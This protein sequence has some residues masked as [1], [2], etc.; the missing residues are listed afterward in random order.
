[1][2][3]QFEDTFPQ[4][5]ERVLDR[6]KGVRKSL[7][8]WTACCP[9]HDDQTPSL[10]IGLGTD[11]RVLL[12]CFAGCSFES[13][14]AA[15]GLQAS[16]LFP[17]DPASSSHHKGAPLHGISL[18]DLALAKKIP[19][20]FLCNLGIIEE[21][22]GLR[23]PYY[24][25]DG[26]LAPRYRIRTALV[27]R[28]GS[29]WNKNAGEI[30]PYGLERLE[31]ARQAGFLVLVEGESDCW[32]LWLQQFPALGLP[33]AEMAGKLKE[34]Y[35][36]GIERLYIVCEDTAGEKLVEGV[37]HLL[38]TWNWPGRG[39]VVSLLDAKDPNELHQRDWKGFK[40]VFQSALDQAPLLY[41]PEPVPSEPVSS[42]PVPTE[43]AS[44]SQHPAVVTLEGL[45]TRPHEEA[46]WII[47][48]L[49]PEGVLLLGGKPKQGKSW[50][51]LALAL[52]IAAG[53]T[54]LSTY[55][56]EQGEVLFLALEDTEVRL[57]T[58][59]RQLLASMPTIPSSA[60]TFGL[61]WS[62]F[63]EGGLAQ[64]EAY[65]Q[66]HPRLRF[67]VID[68]WAK[69]APRVKGRSQYE[70]DYASLSTMKQLGERYHLSILVIHHLRKTQAHDVLDEMMGS[71]A[72]IGA[73]DAI[74][75]LK[76]D[77]GEGLAS[78]FVTGRDITQEQELPLF[79]DH[80]T[81][82]WLLRDED[83]LDAVQQNDQ[84]E[85]FPAEPKGENEQP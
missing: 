30:L 27:A 11:G 55:Q 82:W 13:I 7:K 6:L 60:I 40:E 72:M 8:G 17:I 41:Q 67:I 19:W 63:D 1:M 57:Q 73:V 5:L 31:Q 47:P 78:L 21:T 83:A 28:E 49:I 61:Q 85:A 15:I 22:R 58:R 52:T 45:L 54:I 16:D 24:S 37:V 12:H 33:G 29:W 53:S 39:Y 10:S 81:G 62:R 26:T 34:E 65:I 77:R 2:V 80:S 69:V 23:I 46:H 35:L 56:A 9:S 44:A 76:R 59:T 38:T 48:D 36:A 71:T 51:A 75:I 18:L 84:E 4:T 79:F 32:T 43:S 68:T 50:F 66:E 64:L 14:I 70:E 25:P 3:H 74:L 42:E 20:R